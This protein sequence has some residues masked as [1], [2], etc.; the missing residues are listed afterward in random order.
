MCAWEVGKAP[1]SWGQGLV[2]WVET[3][4]VVAWWWR[5]WSVD[6]VCGYVV[7]GTALSRRGRRVWRRAKVG[8]LLG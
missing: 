1:R 3:N 6:H 2:R 8:C 5:P 4:V 7:G